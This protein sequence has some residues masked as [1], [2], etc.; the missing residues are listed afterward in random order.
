MIRPDGSATIIQPQESLALF[1]TGY[2]S[3]YWT[4][5]QPSNHSWQVADSEKIARFNASLFNGGTY[6]ISGS[7]LETRADVAQVPMFTS[8]SATFRMAFSADTLVLTGIN[9]V[10][11]D[12]VQHPLYAGGGHVVNKLVKAR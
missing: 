10:S 1:A 5:H 4:S 7:V 11:V 2:Y 6:K 8:G 12:G 3:M 9:V